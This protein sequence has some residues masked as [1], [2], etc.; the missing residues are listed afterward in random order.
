MSYV[1][2]YRFGDVT[3][4]FT[5]VNPGFESGSF[6]PWVAYV[7]SAGVITNY[8]SDV[9][10]RTGTYMAGTVQFGLGNSPVDYAQNLSVPAYYWGEIDL[11]KVTISNV[12]GYHNPGVAAGGGGNDRGRLYLKFFD[13][14]G[15]QIGSTTYT[16]WNTVASTWTLMSIPATAV[17][18]GTRSVRIGT[19]N[20]AEDAVHDNFWDDFSQPALAI[21]F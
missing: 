21:T 20:E 12:S 8:V 9:F 15:A 17:P 4:G 1:D 3:A 13:S 2:P 7:G 14:V 18:S 5:L 19:E 6:S 10:P 11:G 16:A